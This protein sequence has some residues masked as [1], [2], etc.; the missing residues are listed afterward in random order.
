ML[1]EL[2]RVLPTVDVIQEASLRM[3]RAHDVAALFAH[4]E[5]TNEKYTHLAGIT[6][7]LIAKLVLAFHRTQ[8]IAIADLGAGAH[9]EFYQRVWRELLSDPKP[10]CVYWVDAAQTMLDL[11]HQYLVDTGNEACEQV[12]RYRCQDMLQF[13]AGQPAQALD[14]IVMRY[15]FSW[16]ADVAG[17][18]KEA[19]RTLKKGGKMIVTFAKPEPVIASHSSNAR[20]RWRGQD[21]PAG[22]T[23]PL[24]EGEPYEVVFSKAYKD[25]TQGDLPGARMW[26]YF[27]S[28]EEV[29]RVA[30]AAGLVVRYGDWKT[31][32]DVPQDSPC[33]HV[34][35]PFLILHRV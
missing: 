19:Q 34:A 6:D 15:T 23:R 22:E 28:L 30:A 11:A 17:F 20:Y 12:L 4:R 24:L 18:L 31:F 3:Y 8:P 25:P 16:V 35:E 32:V 27:H 33:A 7:I 10:H 2:S 9:P 5:A 1:E 29:T 21:I 13:L 14:C 26:V